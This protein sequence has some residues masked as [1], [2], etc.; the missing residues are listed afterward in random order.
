MGKAPQNIPLRVAR[1]E[2]WD[3]ASGEGCMSMEGLGNEGCSHRKTPWT[4]LEE[5]KWRLGR[6]RG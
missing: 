4:A 3:A 2:S 6:A 1:S 5:G